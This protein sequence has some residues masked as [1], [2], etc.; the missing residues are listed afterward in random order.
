MGTIERQQK[1]ASEIFTGIGGREAAVF[2]GMLSTGT[3]IAMYDANVAL[4]ANVTDGH[5]FRYATHQPE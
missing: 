1:D 2:V 4:C 5:R 3:V